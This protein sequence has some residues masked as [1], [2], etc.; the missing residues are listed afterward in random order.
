MKAWGR[1]ETFID[2]MLGGYV[3]E[4]NDFYAIPLSNY[5]GLRIFYNAD[6]T[7]KIKRYALGELKARPDAEWIQRCVLRTE[8]GE[9][10]GYLPI[11]DQLKDWL[12]D[13]EVTPQTLGQLFFFCEATLAYAEKN[14]LPNL[15]PISTSSY[16]GNNIAGIYERPF[17]RNVG[18]DVNMMPGSEVSFLEVM[19]SYQQGKWDFY[20]PAIRE[21]YRLSF[22]LVRYFPIG[23]LGKDREQA[24]RRFVLGD[25]VMLSSGGWD[26]SSVIR[27]VASRD[28]EED[29]FEVK[30]AP[31]PLPDEDERWAEMIPMHKTEANFRAGVPLAVNLQ[32]H[33]FEWALDFLKYM[34][35]LKINEEFNRRAGWLP[36]I[37]G[38][39][40]IEYMEPF[41]P[42]REGISELDSFG[43]GGSEVRSSISSA[44]SSNAKLYFGG[45]I[46]YDEFVQRVDEVLKQPRLGIESQW[47]TT[48]QKNI[49]QSRA[50]DRSVS[51]SRF[52]MM[53]D[54]TQKELKGYLAK[55]TTSVES[56][57]GRAIFRMWKKFNGEEPFPENE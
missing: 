12:A 5:G 44:V 26:A 56:D 40:P 13:G 14:N 20:T 28:N 18:L 55:L 57:E 39:E 21:Y 43:F 48:L 15:V 45:E 36:A 54:G 24:Q 33:H 31:A 37:E 7:G 51:V 30:I 38:G 4:L 23:Y 11:D 2:G 19:E 29:H 9:E 53:F 10:V 25:A 16:G 42:I 27:G 41:S 1:R 22:E 49:D 35:S 3:G 6:L 32:S 17:F 46:G 47:R 34:T 50:Q 8:N 52:R